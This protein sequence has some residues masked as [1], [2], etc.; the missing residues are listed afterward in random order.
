[1]AQQYPSH[2]PTALHWLLSCTH[3][4][5]WES[6]SL[7]SVLSLISST[8]TKSESYSTNSVM[9]VYCLGSVVPISKVVLF[10]VN[11]KSLF[12]RVIR[13]TTPVLNYVIIMGALL[14][15]LSVF[16]G[17]LPSTEESIVRM[18]CLVRRTT[19]SS[20]DTMIIVPLIS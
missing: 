2:T 17:V 4:L 14:M 18:Q 8:E 15:Y 19:H 5:C 20:L 7:E 16:F 11:E 12:C 3:W 1:M 13:L 10:F 9:R 6:F